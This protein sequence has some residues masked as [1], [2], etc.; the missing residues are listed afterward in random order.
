VRRFQW[1][2]SSDALALVVGILRAKPLAAQCFDHIGPAPLKFLAKI[3]LEAFLASLDDDLHP[4]VYFIAYLGSA[5][6]AS[7]CISGGII[8][9]LPFVAS[10][11]SG[12]EALAVALFDVSLDMPADAPGLHTVYVSKDSSG[13][14]RVT[15]ELFEAAALVLAPLLEALLRARVGLVASQ[16][17]V[18]P[19]L[20]RHLEARG[21]V[22]IARVSGAHTAAV[23]RVTGAQVISDPWSMFVG[24]PTG[25]NEGQRLELPVTFLGAVR[26]PEAK[27]IDGRSH[28]LLRTPDD[29]ALISLAS[30]MNTAL[31]DS[32][33]AG[34][35]EKGVRARRAGVA[36]LVLA[37]P[38]RHVAA[39]VR[40]ILEGAIITLTATLEEPAVLRGAGRWEVAAV[41]QVRRRAA[42]L[43]QSVGVCALLDAG[44]IEIVRATD[45]ARSFRRGLEVFAECLEETA[46]SRCGNKAWIRATEDALSSQ[47]QSSLPKLFKGPVESLPACVNALETAVDSA[48]CLLRLHGTAL[49]Y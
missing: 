29:G 39:E 34:A 20:Q 4:H 44:A 9:D 37:A 32:S 26:I 31:G 16:R 15:A 43:E 12:N 33:H 21:V 35:F 6:S 17:L 3:T 25:S 27:M 41:A 11:L 40:A 22:V 10:H 45:D 36:T 48:T 13:G 38:D 24:Q 1:N 19:W 5:L 2:D 42:A 47:P 8:L 28:L 7:E 14:S 46:R 23:Q 49:N 30:L 18:H